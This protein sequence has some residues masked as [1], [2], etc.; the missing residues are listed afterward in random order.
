MD[1]S[2]DLMRAYREA[3]KLSDDF[4]GKKKIVRYLKDRVRVLFPA[5]GAVPAATCFNEVIIH[6]GRTDV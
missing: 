3:K 5:G 4:P 1:E 6:D 2:T